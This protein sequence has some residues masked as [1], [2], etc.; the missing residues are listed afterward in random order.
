MLKHICA[1]GYIIETGPDEYTPN[2]FTKSLSLPIIAH[3]YPVWYV[4]ILLYMPQHALLTILC[5]SQSLERQYSLGQ[6]AQV[7]QGN[8]LPKPNEPD[9]WQL[10][11]GA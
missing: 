10:P 3:S 8:R 4:N 11:A 5:E 2:N 1:M 7:P 6:L 9:R